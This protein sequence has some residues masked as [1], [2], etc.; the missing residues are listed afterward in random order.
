[1]LC[2][3]V[4]FRYEFPGV[5]KAASGIIPVAGVLV[6]GVLSVAY[7]KARRRF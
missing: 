4:A 5:I 1:M 6:S 2:E 3:P 7:T